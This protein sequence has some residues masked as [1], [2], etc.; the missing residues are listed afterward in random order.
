MVKFRCRIIFEVYIFTFWIM[1]PSTILLP[2]IFLYI[3]H[4]YS[5]I[6]LLLLSML[7]FKSSP[8]FLT[9]GNGGLSEAVCR[10]TADV[11]KCCISLGLESEVRVKVQNC[12]F[13]S[14]FIVKFV[15]RVKRVLVVD[16]SEKVCH[17]VREQ[18]DLKL[19]LLTSLL[20]EPC[21]VRMSWISGTQSFCTC[22]DPTYKIKL[23]WGQ[24]SALR[25]FKNNLEILLLL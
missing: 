15:A 19:V 6:Y 1:P 8:S 4:P 20:S 25:G 22:R 10:K 7:S 11:K 23:L 24:F 2:F 14:L 9:A 13:S 21:I 12:F 16:R 17:P 5:S 18:I 3:H